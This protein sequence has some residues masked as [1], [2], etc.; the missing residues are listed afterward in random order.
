MIIGRLLHF[1]APLDC[2]A[3]YP[4]M[5]PLPAA[6]TLSCP[7]PALSCPLLVF[8]LRFPGY[9]YAFG[10]RM[11]PFSQKTPASFYPRP[12]D[13]A[14]FL[15]FAVILLPS[16]EGCGF[17]RGVGSTKGVELGICALSPTFELGGQAQETASE[18][19]YCS[20]PLGKLAKVCLRDASGGGRHRRRALRS[21][22]AGRGGK[23][24]GAFPR[25]LP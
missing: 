22:A 18:G 15:V 25:A 14:L 9:P 3:G 23:V 7:Y 5:L 12:K 21:A 20:R 6:L 4:S 1:L 13:T 24:F 16:A 19:D 11:S 2:S 8:F 17:S 10:Q